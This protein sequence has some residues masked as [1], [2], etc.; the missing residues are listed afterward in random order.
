MIACLTGRVLSTDG[1][2]AVI[3][4]AGV[5]YRVYASAR[6][7][8]TVHS[9]QDVRVHTRL[10]VREDDV[11]LYGFADDGEAAMFDLVLSVHGIGPK[12]AIGLLSVYGPDDLRH[13]IATDDVRMIQRVPGVGAKMASRIVLELKGRLPADP[14]ATSPQQSEAAQVLRSL[15]VSDDEAISILEGLDGDVSDVVRQ[16]LRRLAQQGGGRS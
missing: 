16:A 1:T 4:V 13:L 7:L 12:V 14:A 15:G 9:G 3:D 5:G 6:T 8:G 11:R 10:L 2:S